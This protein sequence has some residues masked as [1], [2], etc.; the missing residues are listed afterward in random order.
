MGEQT[1]PTLM[2]GPCVQPRP[3]GPKEPKGIWFFG[4]PMNEKK[5]VDDGRDIFVNA[6]G[7]RYHRQ[8]INKACPGSMK[9]PGCSL[10]F[11]VYDGKAN[12]LAIG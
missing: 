11:M 5:H 4:G 3:Q 7:D 1:G 6:E 10:E 2:L 8:K 12:E 9:G